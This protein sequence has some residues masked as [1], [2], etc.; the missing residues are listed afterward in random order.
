M[1]VPGHSAGGCHA[2]MA[3]LALEQEGIDLAA[4]VL[5]CSFIGGVL[6]SFSTLSQTQQTNLPPTLFVLADNDPISDGS[7]Q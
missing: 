7:L 3:T 5:C 1:K 2:A 6:D 4:P